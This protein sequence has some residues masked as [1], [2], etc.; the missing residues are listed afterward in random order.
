M[1]VLN[2]NPT[3]MELNKLKKQLLVARR[4]HKLLKDKRDELMRQFLDIIRENRQLREK[5]EMLIRDSHQQ[6]LLASAVMDPAVARAALMVG[7]ER[8]EIGV[9][10]VNVMSVDVPVFKAGVSQNSKTDSYPYGMAS[11]PGE[12]D[13][14]VSSLNEA[15]PVMLKLAEIEKKAQLLAD[16]IEKTRRRVNSLE[17]VMIPNFEQTIRSIT[18][19]LDESERGNLTRLMKVKDMIVKQALETARKADEAASI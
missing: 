2:V 1:A 6:F 3:R 17:Y 7:K 8:L 9:E 15:F 13:M 10:T 18:M 14:A 5:S 16:E 19:K 4:G 11:T 12:L